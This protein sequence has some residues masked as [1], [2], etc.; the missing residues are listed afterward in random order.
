MWRVFSL[1][2]N[3]FWQHFNTCY[4][5][6]QTVS[7]PAQTIFNLHLPIYYIPW[8]FPKRLLNKW[9]YSCCWVLLTVCELADPVCCV[10]VCCTLKSQQNSKT[11]SSTAVVENARTSLP[12]GECPLPE[13]PETMLAEAGGQAGLPP[14]QRPGGGWDQQKG[15]A[16]RV[17]DHQVSVWRGG[18]RQS[19]CSSHGHRL[20][21]QCLQVPTLQYCT[22]HR[23]RRSGQRLSWRH[24]DGWKGKNLLA[25]RT[26]QGAW[27]GLGCVFMYKSWGSK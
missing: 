23:L 26:C 14:L 2:Q 16:G 20:S 10:W 15:R 8:P 27:H 6:I 25:I 3:E 13:E 4:L 21:L 17:G 5:S 1:Q 9:L 18:G 7:C 19:G 11:L 24:F 22:L 12:P